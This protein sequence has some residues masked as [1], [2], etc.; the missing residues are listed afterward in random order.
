MKKDAPTIGN[1]LMMRM[2]YQSK[3]TRAKTGMRSFSGVD[4]ASKMSRGYNKTLSGKSKLEEDFEAMSIEEIDV[5]IEKAQR[6]V[7]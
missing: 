5:L 2:E 3:Q 7:D 6:E 4:T 1:P